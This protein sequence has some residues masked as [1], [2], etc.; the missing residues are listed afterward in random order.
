VYDVVSSP[1][2]VVLSHTQVPC[3]IGPT[4]TTEASLHLDLQSG[5]MCRKTADSRTGLI[6]VS[7]SCWGR[8][9]WALG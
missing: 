5:T 8:F 9:V 6:T 1:V 3:F 2:H 7:D 4:K